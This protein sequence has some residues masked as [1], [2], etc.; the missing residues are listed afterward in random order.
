MGVVFVVVEV[1]EVF[2]KVFRPHLSPVAGQCYY[3]VPGELY[4]SCLMHIDVAAVCGYH[5]LVLAE[6]R[7]DDGGVGL[8]APGQE[9]YHGVFVV[10]GCHYLGLC[11]FAELVGPV[12]Q[13]PLF[14]CLNQSLQHL[15]VCPVVIIVFK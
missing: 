4:G 8:R 6:Q 1:F 2:V 14:V 10:A 12:G 7:V 13:C 15:W 11:A 3:L 9:E 5:S